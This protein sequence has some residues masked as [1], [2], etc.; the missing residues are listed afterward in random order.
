[1]NFLKSLGNFAF[2]IFH[3]LIFRLFIFLAKACHVVTLL[4]SPVNG[5]SH[6]LRLFSHSRRAYRWRASARFTVLYVNLDSSFEGLDDYKS[7]QFKFAFVLHLD[8]MKP[9]RWFQNYVW[10]S[11]AKALWLGHREMTEFDLEDGPL[12]TEATGGFSDKYEVKEKLGA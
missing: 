6:V 4:W 10:E 1:M 3:F 12:G 2:F 9:S 8:E 5:W 11:K 7:L